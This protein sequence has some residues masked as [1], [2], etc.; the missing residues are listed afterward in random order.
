MDGVFE[1]KGK[2]TLL[3]K[4]AKQLLTMEGEGND[5]LG[6]IE[7]GSIFIRNGVIEAVGT[8]SEVRAYLEGHGSSAPFF[9][10]VGASAPGCLASGG[11]GGETEARNGSGS[12]VQALGAPGSQAQARNA[13]GGGKAAP[14]SPGGGPFESVPVVDASGRV[15]SPGFVDC[16]TH[17]VFG[18]SRARAYC[19]GLT[20]SD[21]SVLER[22]HIPTGIYASVDMT[23]ALP[24]ETVKAQAKKRMEN[25]ILHGTTTIESKSGYGLTTQSELAMLR[26][27]RELAD[28][29]PL[30]V[31]S[32]FLGAHGWTKGMKKEDYIR[33]LCEEMI[34]LVAKEKLAAC[35]DVW[36]DEGHYT[37][38]E[39]EQILSCG[40]K[41]GLQ[42]RIHT[43]AYSY[44]GGSDLAAE[45]NMLSADHLN[46]T[47]RPLYR[48]LAEAGVTGVLLVGTDFA[49]A[50]ERPTR[51]RLML[52]DGMELAL[53]TNCCPGCWCESMIF[54]MTLACRLHQM[55]PAQSWRA[56]TRG[57]ARAMGL[58]DRG[59]LAPGMA[60]DVL[61][62]DMDSYE[63]IVYKYGRNPVETVIKS[64]T[65]VA[66]DG[67][68]L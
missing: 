62:L 46:F 30:T 55:S 54:I 58:N 29:L 11:S 52:E 18:G 17:T 26:I 12:K 24:W 60:G 39:S 7:N 38:E 25:M 32:T 15:V 5:E 21:P 43:D 10:P 34:P 53:A 44:I 35:C 66:K 56:A 59:R 27:N 68:L 45:M 2:G 8:D 16:H 3:I 37:A 47:P 14:G 48:K 4:N 28:E 6:I 19:V 63:D 65:A 61:I 50:H 67:R 51:P 20:D 33:L 40:L 57:A 9:L 42:P 23:A 41:Y 13:S 36:C 22:L 64:G 49:V 1:R 31:S